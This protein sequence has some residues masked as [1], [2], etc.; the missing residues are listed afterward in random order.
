[1]HNLHLFFVVLLLTPASEALKFAAI[2]GA[3]AFFLPVEQGWND[4]CNRLGVDCSYII[5]DF[6]NQ[7][8]NGTTSADVCEDIILRLREEG[9]DGLAL[10]ES[11]CVGERMAPLVEEL[12][13]EGIPV[14]LFDR[15]FV[16]ANRTA[17]VGTNNEM[18]GRTMAR[19]LKQL[20]PEGGTF[21]IVA[22]IS[23]RTKGF[24]EE[25]TRDNDRED[26]THWHEIEDLTIISDLSGGPE[27]YAD[28]MDQYA[29]KHNPSA[30]IIMRQTP[31]YVP[32]FLPLLILCTVTSFLIIPLSF[33]RRFVN[34]TQLVDRHRHRGI[35]YIGTDGSDY[36]LG[37][38]HRKYVD[39]LI[40][41]LP[42][43]F[44][45]TSL[46]IL[47]DVV[48]GKKQVE[49]TV[50][51]NLVT[52]NLIP[53]ELPDLEVNQNLLSDLKYIGWI[54]F[55]L[56]ALSVIACILWTYLNREGIVVRA[57]QP[58]FLVMTAVG[59][60]IMGSTLIPLSF[61][62]NG[63]PYA[64]TEFKRIGICM[65]IPWLSFT[66]FTVIF[67]ALFSKTWRI[68]TLVNQSTH[69][70]RATVETRDVIGPFL[71]LISC[72]W[73]VLLSWTFLDP[74]KYYREYLPGTDI[75][76]REFASTGS[77][78]SEN[79]VAYLVLL[80]LRKYKIIPR[81]HFFL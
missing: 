11:S 59:V 36:Q 51:T 14:V 18:M 61:D 52:Y 81:Y 56:I 41:Q 25:I 64:M 32:L 40:G 26:R 7:V 5:P 6:L 69:F 43:E 72:N 34:W 66:G 39:G 15:D 9:I 57:S 60:L 21:V 77:C 38:L 22:G 42:Y 62:D 33:L 8:G 44:G 23:D 35:S 71:A 3:S 73:I 10:G 16:P 54:C 75:W 19:L 76:N 31:M 79:Q 2:S 48:V 68:N 78:Q 45:S 4:N 47:Y 46:Q 29:V 17:Y 70:V 37:Y 55:G 30:F 12:E 28:I 58:V 80:G 53:L 24:V 13:N 65:S 27:F 63:N 1:M 49:S 20:R 74:L 50:Q 67:S